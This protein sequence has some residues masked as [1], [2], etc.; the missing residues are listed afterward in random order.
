MKKKLLIMGLLA[1]SLNVIAG[2]DKG[3]GG[4]VVK[5]LAWTPQG[6]VS[7][8]LDAKYAYYTLDYLIAL[9]N[10]ADLVEV[11]HTKESI[12]RISKILE[13]KLPTLAKKLQKFISNYM[14]S[15]PLDSIQWIPKKTIELEDENVLDYKLPSFCEAMPRSMKGYRQAVLRKKYGETLKFYY[16][17]DVFMSSTDT[18]GI[19]DNTNQES[20]MLIHEFLR[21][22]FTDA[23]D[24]RNVNELFHSRL[25]ENTDSKKLQDY[26]QKVG[27]GLFITS[28]QVDQFKALLAW[29]LVLRP[30]Q[31]SQEMKAEIA[32]LWFSKD[33]DLAGLD[34][35]EISRNFF[36]L[37]R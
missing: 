24:I 12:N 2:G 10:N 27:M 36:A 31:T 32:S 28:G 9:N 16:N 17:Q 14:K 30:G 15:A 37:A 1:V 29:K 35:F 19:S 33:I 34:F 23:E 18:I 25:L 13:Q 22:Y 6:I 5:C 21:D 8:G 7:G 11:A 3:N 20:W 26:L 4:D